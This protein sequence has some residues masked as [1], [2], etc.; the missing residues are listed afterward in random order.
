MGDFVPVSRPW[1]PDGPASAYKTYRIV[2]PPS[3]LRPATCEEVDCE[4][5]AKGWHTYLDVSDPAHASTANWIR[6][7]SGRKY[8]LE[9]SGTAVS[10]FFPPGQ[11]CFIAHRVVDRP[12]LFLVSGGDWRGNPRGV[13]TIRHSG[14][15][16]WVDDFGE[17]QQAIH[18]R[19]SKG[20]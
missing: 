9:Q 1:E 10:F 8:V 17:N 18:D 5:L 3:H 19:I 16:A 12:P 4:R 6:L 2:S 15:Q 13:P 11:Q 7:H 20:V 14:V